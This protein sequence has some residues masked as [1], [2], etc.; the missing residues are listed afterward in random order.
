VYNNRT[1]TGDLEKLPDDIIVTNG[2][3]LVNGKHIDE[4]NEKELQLNE[5][6]EVYYNN[7]QNH[8]SINLKKNKRFLR[9]YNDINTTIIEIL[10]DKDKDNVPENYFFLLKNY[11]NLVGEEINI[12]QIYIL[13]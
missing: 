10:I 7:K 6:I 4:F 5:S 2:N 1:Y 13:V 8:F 3:I 11:E 12:I 9:Y